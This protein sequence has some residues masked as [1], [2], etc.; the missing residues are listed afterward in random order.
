MR[1]R[2][3]VP[4][5]AARAEQGGGRR[6]PPNSNV[7]SR[8]RAILLVV[9]RGGM[10]V[11]IEISLFQVNPKKDLVVVVSGREILRK[12][13]KTA[14]PPQMKIFSCPPSPPHTARTAAESERVTS[15]RRATSDNDA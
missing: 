7:D 1:T 6:P 8:R 5:A 3:L 9:S 14:F 12:A 11:D 4:L 2:R 15:T 10:L 13:D